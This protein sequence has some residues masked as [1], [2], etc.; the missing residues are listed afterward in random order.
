MSKRTPT[1]AAEAL[2]LQ[3]AETERVISH[4]APL[5]KA[6]GKSYAIF[7]LN[8]HGDGRVALWLSAP[9]GAQAHW[10]E[11]DPQHYFVPP[12]VGPRG[13][14]GVTLNGDLA[15]SAICERVRE[16]YLHVTPKRLHANVPAT[17]SSPPPEVALSAEAIDPLASAA[18]QRL[19]QRLRAIC[20]AL[21]E[22]SETEQFGAPTWKAGKRSFACF[23]ADR[24]DAGAS[25]DP[26][27]RLL[28]WVGV[29][30]QAL[31]GE[32][33]RFSI[34]AYLGHLGWIALRLGRSIDWGEVESL[35]RDS[36]RHFALKRMLK[37]L[38]AASP[39]PT[40]SRPRRGGAR[41]P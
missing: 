12:Y 27:L 28:V 23:T 4:G 35:V 14:L 13:W 40:K 25:A 37:Q 3:L 9:P 33:P 39:A 2:C 5:F 30:R 24:D 36:Y 7:A 15:W 32:D 1:E 16:A 6:A 31:M 11:I 19:L 41:R 17:L 10:C 21:P 8:H 34:P 26:A 22:S 29:E 38:D 18:A 20:L